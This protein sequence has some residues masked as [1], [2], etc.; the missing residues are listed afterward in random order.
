MSSAE[1]GATEPV[2]RAGGTFREAVKWSYVMDGGR[3][4]ITTLITLVVA[5]ALGPEPYGLAAMALVYVLFMQMLQ[6]Q[7]MQSAI[8]QRRDL[9]PEHLDSAF[10]AILALS[11]VLTIVSIGLSGWWADVNDLP[12]LQEVVIVLSLSLPIQGLTL[13]QEAVVRRAM[14]FRAL[15]LR[16]NVAVL[17]GGVA[18]VVLAVGGAGVWALVAQQLL[19]ALVG[20][21]LLWRLSSWR[22]RWGYSRA[23]LG[24]LVA[25]SVPSFVASF[26][27]FLGQRADALLIGIF[28]GP[29]AVGLYRFAARLVETVT[30]LV[31]RAMQNAALP[32]LSRRQHDLPAF[33]ERTLSII[34]MSAIF[35]LPVLSLLASGADDI[36]ALLGE[37][38]WGPAAAVLRL[39]CI[40]GAVRSLTL[41]TG[42]MLQALG[43]PRIL[44]AMSWATAAASATT[45]VL[46]GLAVRDSSLEVQV[47]GIAASR[48]LLHF[49]FILVAYLAPAVLLVGLAPSR[50]ARA[51]A[52]AALAAGAGFVVSALVREALIANLVESALVRLAL[53]TAVSI[54]TSGSILLLLSPLARS[55]A[56]QALARFLPAPVPPAHLERPSVDEA[57]Q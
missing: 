50:L 10:W 33:A 31:V 46:V 48:A 35:A 2:A 40:V 39:L 43:R 25:F 13:V 52:P 30:D 4:I 56:K 45:F 16:T 27:V 53:V 49:P 7:G 12:E 3:Q 41:F 57:L 51:I 38:A 18:A 24:D 9:R 20:L 22:P 54:I 21:G 37:E 11:G 6:N 1:G 15:A 36:M 8:I 14:D 32:E 34:S 55:T 47:V 17:V 19:T 44:A 23:A 5:R 42:P 28:F 26:A 29:V